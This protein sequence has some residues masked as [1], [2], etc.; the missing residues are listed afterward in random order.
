[1]LWTPRSAISTCGK[2]EGCLMLRFIRPILP[3]PEEWAPHLEETYARRH[4]TNF[5]PAVTRLEQSLA[6]TYGAGREVILASSATTGI[7]ASLLAF[8]VR[9]R[10]ALPAFTF[11]ATASAILQANCTP[12]FCDVRADTWELDETGVGRAH[13]EAPLSAVVAVRAFGLCRDMTPLANQTR[14]WGIPLII[15][16]AAALGGQLLSGEYVGCQGDAEVFSL[17][18][19]KAFGVGEGGA[20]FAPPDRMAAIRRACN[21]GL[22]GGDVAC[23]G[24]NAKM[25]DFHAAIGLALLPHFP[26]HVARRRSVANAYRRLIAD[27]GGTTASPDSGWP[28]WQTFPVL[29]PSSFDAQQFVADAAD[30]GVELRRYYHP[31]L[32]ETKWLRSRCPPVSTDLSRR[33]VCLPV[34]SD[35]TREELMRVSGVVRKSWRQ[36]SRQAAPSFA[37]AG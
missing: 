18:A 26:A 7:A 17:H 1:M 5:G 24:L 2:S 20:I 31:A 3:P 14:C 12:V 29:L 35:M 11:P 37:R 8:G 13:R 19:T 6:A 34:Y 36:Q 9:G 32:P 21:F 25:S 33:M 4:F 15:D 27:L 22:E 23:P 30:N 28:V 16:A 10:V